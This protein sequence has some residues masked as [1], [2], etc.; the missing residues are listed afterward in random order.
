MRGV[1]NPELFRWNPRDI[2]HGG[3]V[4]G[5]SWREGDFRDLLGR[6]SGFDF[7]VG[8]L[9]IAVV[10]APGSSTGQTRV[11]QRLYPNAGDL[12]D[13]RLGLEHIG[14]RLGVTTRRQD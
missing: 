13:W 14:F 2:Q 12:W 8:D 3:P 1:H 6:G 11:R 7:H 4:I 10:V 5:K 9:E